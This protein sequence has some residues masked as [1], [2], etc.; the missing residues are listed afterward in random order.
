[1][2]TTWLELGGREGAREYFIEETDIVVGDGRAELRTRFRGRADRRA[3]KLN[4]K[5]IFPSYR[6]EVVGVGGR[7]E[8]LA[9]QNR[10]VPR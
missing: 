8:V 3:R 6:Y 2:S 5:R 4:A 7:W 10:A 9:L 1:M